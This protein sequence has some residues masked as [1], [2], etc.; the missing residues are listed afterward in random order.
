MFI[1]KLHIAL[2]Q[3]NRGEQIRVDDR[4]LVVRLGNLKELG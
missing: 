3:A 2:G 4:F 1:A